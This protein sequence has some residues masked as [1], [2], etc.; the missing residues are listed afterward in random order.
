MIQHS[1]VG[2]VITPLFETLPADSAAEFRFDS[3]FKIQV[4]DE[5]SF[6]LVTFPA[7]VTWKP[8]ELVHLIFTTSATVLVEPPHR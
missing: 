7:F 4:P 6:L 8:S 2:I 1:H 5:V 3:A